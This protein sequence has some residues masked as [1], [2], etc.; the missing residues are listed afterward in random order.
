MSLK[1]AMMDIT[2]SWRVTALS[3]SEPNPIATGSHF[4]IYR[5]YVHVHVISRP[6]G[7]ELNDGV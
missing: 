2:F 4:P 7:S 1:S 6:T 5:H 3:E